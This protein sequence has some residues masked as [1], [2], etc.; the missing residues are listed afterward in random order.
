MSRND[1]SKEW[2]EIS[3]VR[4]MGLRNGVRIR[5]SESW[6]WCYGSGVRMMGA[7][8]GFAPD[9][10]PLRSNDSDLFMTRPMIL[11]Y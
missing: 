6:V 11:T 9:Q 1:G 3:G 2:G 7:E 8:S 5:M 10:M 4:I